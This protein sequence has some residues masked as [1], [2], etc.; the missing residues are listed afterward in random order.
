MIKN[1]SAFHSIQRLCQAFDLSTSSYYRWL[2]CPVGKRQREDQKLSED[3]KRIFKKSR[4]TYGSPRMQRALREEGKRH[5][6]VRL[7]RLM[8]EL[9]L[10]PKAARLFKVTTN[11]QH[12]K[13]VAP[14]IL[15]QRFSPYAANVAWATDIT[16]IRTDEGWLYL[17]TVIDLY[18]RRIIGWSMGTRLVT[19]LI[20]DAL[21]MALLQRKPPQGV[22]HHSDRGSQYCSAVYQALLSK[23][24]FICSMSG[25]GNC[26]DNAVME[27]FYHTLKVELIYGHRYRTR[28]KA[29]MAI[30]DYIEIFY[31]RERLHSSLDY[32]TPEAFEKAA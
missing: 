31:N 11:S 32:Q 30:F 14:N 26:Y 18:S 2:K 6:K 3:I 19:K 9:N 22:I 24:G 17:A 20:I 28:G 15:G 10:K 5:G 16:Y 8:K 7:R 27:S 13:P 4:S 12:N 23:H 21:A 25:K 1:Q 29:I